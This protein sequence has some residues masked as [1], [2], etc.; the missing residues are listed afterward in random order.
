[1]ESISCVN[2]ARDHPQ[3]DSATHT[4]IFSGRLP[5]A[6]SSNHPLAWWS[7]RTDRQTMCRAELA[8]IVPK[9][10]EVGGP[11]AFG[12]RGV[13]RRF[14]I[15]CSACFT[16]NVLPAWR[17]CPANR[18]RQ[19]HFSIP[20]PGVSLPSHLGP[21]P[22]G[23]ARDAQPPARKVVASPGSQPDADTDPR[24]IE[25]VRLRRIGTGPAYAAAPEV[26]LPRVLQRSIGPSPPE[27]RC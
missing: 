21:Q 9:C 1:M 27:G 2:V 19:P 16:W 23:A 15:S 3:V 5:T 7:F 13:L 10:V 25:F 6:N 18:M 22:T 14:T 20:F 8:E 26:P 4:E 24:T 12:V 17:R 11:G